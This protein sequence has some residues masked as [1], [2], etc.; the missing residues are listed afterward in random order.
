MKVLAKR[1]DSSIIQHLFTAVL[2]LIILVVW[3]IKFPSEIPFIVA[4]SIVFGYYLVVFIYKVMGPKAIIV[5]DRKDL[6][7]YLYFGKK[8]HIRKSAIT[9]VDTKVYYL[10]RHAGKIFIHIADD[11]IILR[12]VFEPLAVAKILETRE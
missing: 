8:K 1:S 10:N 3:I 11:V 9:K 2:L 5:G 6:N 7:I 12:N 4:L